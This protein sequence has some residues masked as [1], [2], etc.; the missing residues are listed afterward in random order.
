MARCDGE[1]VDIS[2]DF[3]LGF[4]F[5]KRETLQM[6]LAKS[7]TGSYTSSPSHDFINQFRDDPFF[8]GLRTSASTSPACL[9][10]LG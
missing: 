4:T 5:P 3:D 10:N 8:F 6:P 9:V 2:F 1:Y 7:R